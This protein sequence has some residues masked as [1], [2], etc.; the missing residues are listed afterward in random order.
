M[1]YKLKNIY[2]VMRIKGNVNK[3]IFKTLLDLINM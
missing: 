3:I 1:K 2:N